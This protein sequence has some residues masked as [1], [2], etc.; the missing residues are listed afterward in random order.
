MRPSHDFLSLLTDFLSSPKD[1]SATLSSLNFKLTSANANKHPV[2]TTKSMFNI[3]QS[4]IV[5]LW[6]QQAVLHI[7]SLIANTEV[8]PA[9]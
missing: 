4:L 2:L 3:L 6:F 1:P 5:I 9:R 8:L 7:I